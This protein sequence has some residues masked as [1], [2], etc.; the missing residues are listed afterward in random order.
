MPQSC[1]IIPENYRNGIF[2]DAHFRTQGSMI[3]IIQIK[4]VSVEARQKGI[5]QNVAKYLDKEIPLFF[6]KKDFRILR[7]VVGISEF[8]IVS[9]QKVD[10]LGISGDERDR[11][12]RLFCKF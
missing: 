12:Y 6:K 10:C 11:D 8:Q 2:R 7:H 9:F 1:V 4:V 5:I 3:E